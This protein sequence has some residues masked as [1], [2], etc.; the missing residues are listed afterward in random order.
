MFAVWLLLAAFV[1]V[2]STQP[3]GVN[4]QFIYGLAAIALMLCIHLFKL[5]GPMR[6]IFMALGLTIAFRYMY[7]RATSTLPGTDNL[8]SFIP[9]ILLFF[10]EIYSIGM[11]FISAVVSADPVKRKDAPLTGPPG[12]Y[13]TVDIFIPTYNED[14]EILGTT[15]GAAKNLDYPADKINIFLLDDGG[16][17]Q[18]CNDTD[19]EKRAEA[20]ERRVRLSAFCDDMGVQYVTRERNE[21]AKAGNLNNGMKFSDGDI[22]VVFDADHAPVREFL[23]ETVGHMQKDKNLFLVQTPHFFLNPDPVEKNLNTFNYMP[24]ENEMFYSV[25]QK[26]LDK[27]DASFFCGSA[28]LLR[29]EALMTVGGFKGVSITEDCE[30]ALELHSQGWSSAYVDKPMIAGFQPET[31]ASFLIQ[32]ARWCQGMLQ[33]LILRAP[34]MKKGLN[35]MQK[36]AY[37]S[38]MCFWLFPLSRLAFVFAPVL[39]I[40]LDLEIYNASFQE[41][42]AYTCIFMVSSTI[43][44]NYFY[45]KVRW[46]WISETYEYIQAFTLAKTIFNTI[47][48]PRKPT[49]KVT[50]KGASL[51]EDFFSEYGWNYLFA[52]VIL[53]STFLY[54]L[55]RLHQESFA[56]E[57][58]LVVTFWAFFNVVLSGLALGICAER[59]ERR[60]HYRLECDAKNLR[61]KLQ[62][63]DDCF[64]VKIRDLA[65]GGLSVVGSSEKMAPDYRVGTDAKL[66]LLNGTTNREIHTFNT[67]IRWVRGDSGEVTFGMTFEKAT[68]LDRRT[69]AYLMFPNRKNIEAI[70]TRRKRSRGILQGTGVIMVWSFFQSLRGV[71]AALR[72]VA[73]R[74]G[75][76]S[77]ATENTEKAPQ[78]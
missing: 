38:S 45:H 46:P 41:F 51:E 44:Q 27:W 37:L 9:G 62:I 67:G 24:S 33:I 5:R 77:K 11:L 19:P 78:T 26:G 61:G 57:L 43:M 2:I 10:A 66:T 18:K 56:N 73:P 31:M 65:I 20:R 21:M 49:F 50:D 7:W 63:G 8:T 75:G 54:G 76:K 36:I 39:Y 29:R 35:P 30:T 58:L 42:I 47:K 22:I 13:P 70:R 53:T 60:R 16:T 59:R 28:A 64:D 52:H 15:L 12:E 4:A 68:A 34:F 14:D 71:K 69:Q 23:L 6:H 55:Y 40:F 3:V 48:S 74:L 17:D 32:R 1:I 25:T 72:D